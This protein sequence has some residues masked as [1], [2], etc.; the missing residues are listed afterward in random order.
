MAIRDM[1]RIK[2]VLDKLYDKYNRPELIPPDPLQFVYRYKNLR[3]MEVAGLLASSLAYGRV[4]QIERDVSDLLGRMGDSPYQFVMRFDNRRRTAF[5]DFKHR[6]NTGDDI[7][8][9]LL[10]LR[11]VLKSSGSIERHFLQ[12]YDSN[13]ETVLPALTGF[14]GFP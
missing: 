12:F 5:A 8:D 11:E 13:D 9:L 7:C 6:F 2:G 3:D 1:H 10:V 4:R 14:V